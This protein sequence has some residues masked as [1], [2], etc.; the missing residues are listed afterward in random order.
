MAYL[1][2]AN[3]FIQVKNRRYGLDFCPACGRSRCCAVNGRGLFSV[4]NERAAA[5]FLVDRFRLNPPFE[6]EG[7]LPASRR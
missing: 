7:S 5:P 4:R 1:L 2:D 3:V 6:G